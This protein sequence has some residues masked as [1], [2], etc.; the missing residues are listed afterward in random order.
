MKRRRITD[1]QTTLPVT[2]LREGRMIVAYTPALDISTCG[3]TYEE[4]KHNFEELLDIFFDECLSMGT[5]ERVLESC[6][7]R[8]QDK[9]WQPP[10]FI[11]EE[12]MPIPQA[13]SA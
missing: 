8:K 10:V 11:A 2:F 7:W 12:N 4:A 5:L 1:I 3:R 9:K 6:G 13:V